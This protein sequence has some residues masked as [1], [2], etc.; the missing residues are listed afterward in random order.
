MGRCC[1]APVV[2]H[3]IDG[4]RHRHAAEAHDARREAQRRDDDLA[5]AV[6]EGRERVELAGLCQRRRLERLR[7]D[8][9]D[10]RGDARC[11][12]T[13][14]AGAVGEREA[15]RCRGRAGGGL[16]CGGVGARAPP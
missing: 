11:I 15:W 10:A 16:G 2:Q 8:G 14:G 3:S 13:H 5:Q 12:G 9:R 6:E 7:R 4:T 1:D